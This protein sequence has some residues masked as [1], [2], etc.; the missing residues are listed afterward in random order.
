M[1]N[2]VKKIITTKSQV[3]TIL[4]ALCIYMLFASVAIIHHLNER[5][6]KEQYL[7][8]CP[9]PYVCVIP[10]KEWKG[11]TP[12]G[13]TVYKK[14]PVWNMDRLNYLP[15]CIHLNVITRNVRKLLFL[16]YPSM[17]AQSIVEDVTIV[18]QAD[19]NGLR[20]STCLEYWLS[21]R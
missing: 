4:L 6:N 8:I 13:L 21:I 10:P 2:F 11:I 18:T 9:E 16:Y 7:R 15:W 5:I 20:T 14:I 1:K 17:M 19:S 12:M 3:N